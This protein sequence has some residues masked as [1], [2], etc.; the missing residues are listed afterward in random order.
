MTLC[1]L[2]CLVEF[3]M[4]ILDEMDVKGIK[5]VYEHIRVGNVQEKVLKDQPR[6][7]EE[8][9]FLEPKAVKTSPNRLRQMM[10]RWPVDAPLMRVAG[11]YLD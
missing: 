2:A 3:Y 6:V 10:D 1:L 5:I 11:K 4:F 9:A 7:L 8:W